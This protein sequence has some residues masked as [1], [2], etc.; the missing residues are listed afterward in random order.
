MSAVE[1][2]I[3]VPDIANPLPENVNALLPASCA[4]ASFMDTTKTTPKTRARIAKYFTV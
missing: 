1:S 4:S 3:D 2:E